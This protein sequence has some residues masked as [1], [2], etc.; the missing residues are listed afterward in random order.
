MGLCI[1]DANVSAPTWI[2]SVGIWPLPGDLYFF[3]FAVAVSSSISSCTSG[4]AVCTRIYVCVTS[5]TLCTFNSWGYKNEITR[6]H[7]Y[8]RKFLRFW[9]II[10]KWRSTKLWTKLYLLNLYTFK[11]TRLHYLILSFLFSVTKWDDS[12]RN[13]SVAV[14]F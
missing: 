13:H 2:S 10:S 11:N 8:S 5:L 12:S 6:K 4:S 9:T 7:K 1:S 3:N 14:T